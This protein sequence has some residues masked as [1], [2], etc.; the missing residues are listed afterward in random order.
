VSRFFRFL[1]VAIGLSAFV[2]L[3]VFGFAAW[4]FIPLLPAGI[5]FLVAVGAARKRATA[6]PKSEEEETDRRKA[7]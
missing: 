7:A 4:V 3:I 1:A 5:V 2:L 6:P